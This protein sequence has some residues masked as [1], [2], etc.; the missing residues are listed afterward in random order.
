MTED[1]TIT[2]PSVYS[3]TE[4]RADQLGR[5][6][7]KFEYWCVEYTAHRRGFVDVDY[8]PT[9]VTEEAARAHAEK[10]KQRFGVAA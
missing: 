3:Q 4:L 10:L 1:W 6:R 5:L 2:E 7:R 9:F 8:C